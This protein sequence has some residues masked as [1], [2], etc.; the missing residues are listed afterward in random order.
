MNADYQYISLSTQD[1]HALKRDFLSVIMTVA[2]GCQMKDPPGLD[3]NRDS[4]KTTL[5]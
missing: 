1:E 5:S 2:V 4:L 3:K